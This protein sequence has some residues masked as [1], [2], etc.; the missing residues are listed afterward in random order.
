MARALSRRHDR[1][2]MSG[3]LSSLSALERMKFE[4]SPEATERK[5]ELLYRLSRARLPNAKAVHRLHEALCF[6]HAYP[7][8]EDVLL[9]VVGML[10][11]FDYRADLR[12][13]AKQL[14]DTGIAG[15]TITY[16]FFAATAA[17]LAERWP[18]QLTI[19]WDEDTN[20]ELDRQLPLLSRWSES[21]AMDEMPL[22]TR[23]WVEAQ[24]GP[25]CADGAYVVRR[26]QAVHKDPFVF[27]K[28]FESLG[29]WMTLHPTE[30]TPSRTRDCAPPH[31]KV[32]FQRE[33]LRVAR[34][35][36]GKAIR[37][38][39]K[40]IRRVD[41]A[42][43]AGYL[44]LA[45][46]AMLTR[47]R[48][49]DAFAYGDPRD[50]RIVDWEDGLQF[51]AIGLLPERRLLLE[52]VYAFLTLKNGV[53]I[54]YVLNSALFGSAE[55]A[56]NVFDAF[57]GG[58]AAW[59]YGRVLATVRA[60]FG[61]DSFTIY[62]YQLGDDND[63]A[64]QSGAWWFYQKL[65][66]RPRGADARRLMKREL[67]AMEKRPRHRSSIATLRTLAAENMYWHQG[68]ERDDVI[69]LLPL[70]EVGMAA[71]RAL[72][73]RNGADRESAERECTAVAQQLL[74][75]RQLRS[76]TKDEQLWL[77]RWAPIVCLLPGIEKW[78]KKDRRALLDVIRK[79][80]SRSESD[81]VHAFD[82]H[83]PLR[84]A[85]AALAHGKAVAR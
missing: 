59:I 1:R 13:F 78:G 67:A 83:K 47:Q 69:G 16:P 5:L 77:S 61:A 27:E 20:E 9:A 51:V 63:E 43:G 46:D 28:A 82:Q 84:K 85:I 68:K 58:E 15:T 7:D 23:E 64:L 49:L 71:V 42:L 72:A 34:P 39:P 38:R 65:G 40:A 52:S 12:R 10:H 32:A 41:P 62:P 48:D 25:L 26:M 56:Y 55:I 79:K 8:S 18:E 60:L 54:G 29:L 6:M 76:L 2:L 74:G 66:F 11:F 33:P 70:A 81:F 36:V 21:V 3:A 45:R 44:E 50:V 17:R 37:Q 14:A 53:P 35:D 19:C 24:K 75:V 4:F 80:A 57:R 73:Q 22:T 31:G 30:E